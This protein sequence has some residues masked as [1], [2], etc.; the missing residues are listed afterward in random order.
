MVKDA[1]DGHY[2]TRTSLH[3][4]FVGITFGGIHNARLNHM[5]ILSRVR[6]ETNVRGGLFQQLPH[7]HRALKSCVVGDGFERGFA[8]A[9]YDFH[10][11]LLV[12][13]LAFGFDLRGKGGGGRGKGGGGKGGGVR[14]VVG[15]R[16]G[17]VGV[18]GGWG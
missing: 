15:V 18:R 7:D 16:V 1:I 9:L 3:K 12:H 14:V 13:V 5:H 11:H 2:K 8:S 10:T 6:I 17:V 4:S